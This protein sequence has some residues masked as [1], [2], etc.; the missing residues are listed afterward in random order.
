M[1][2]AM[3]DDKDAPTTYCRSTCKIEN[4]SEKFKVTGENYGKQYSN[5]YFVRSQLMKDRIEAAARKKWGD[6]VLLKNLADIKSGEKCCIVG[7]LFKQMELQPSIL[8]EISDEHHLQVQPPRSRFTSETDKLVLEGALQ[9]IS[10]TGNIDPQKCFTGSI[11]ALLGE[12]NVAGQFHIEDMA[13]SG[14]PEQDSLPEVDEE[15]YVL[16]LSG[17]GIG[18]KKEKTFE[19]QLLIDYV[20]G[21]LGGA[22]DHELCSKIVHVVVA[23]N[24]LAG[25]TQDKESQTKAKYLTYKAEAS[26]VQAMNDLDFFLSQLVP[27]VSVDVMSGE[28]D[29]TNHVMPQKPLHPCMFSSARRF[30]NST[31]H[32]VSNPYECKINGVHLLGT[33]G[34]N[35]NNMKMF[36]NI[37]DSAELL[38]LTL[39]AQHLAPTAPDTLGCFPYYKTD[40]FIVNKCP[41]IYFCG[42]QDK[43]SSD[44]ETG[45]NN[46]R[47]LLLSVPAFVKTSSAVLVN[48]KTLDCQ[49]VSFDLEWNDNEMREGTPEK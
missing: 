44:I 40:P 15:Q 38:S 7:T 3:G 20:I 12:E 31:F 16:F 26:T 41:H 22:E 28:F 1:P 6:D 36:G 27:Y 10:L 39:N 9:R 30:N 5:I 2:V 37:S 19:I 34:Q 25:E 8:K 47:V 24:S 45:E 43:F 48:L 21:M 42:N 33:S 13:Y 23:G 46:Q 32:T 17:L 18:S 14:L 35:I 29:P 49:E 11:V 4:L